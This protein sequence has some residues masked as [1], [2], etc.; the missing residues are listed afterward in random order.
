MGN[1]ERENNNAAKLV[2]VKRNQ[3]GG[4]VGGCG[5]G[6]RILGEIEWGHEGGMSGVVK[7]GEQIFRVR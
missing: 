7:G 1:G 3:E 5:L 4:G 2:R 6:E